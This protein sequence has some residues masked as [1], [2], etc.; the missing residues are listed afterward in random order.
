MGSTCPLPPHVTA[1]HS[2]SPRAVATDVAESGGSVPWV[3]GTKPVSLAGVT[4][5]RQAVQFGASTKF[6]P[7]TVVP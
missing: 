1:S 4:L 2:P 3:L 6:V 5:W 7:T